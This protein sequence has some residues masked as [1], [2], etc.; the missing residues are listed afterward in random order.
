M[1][2]RDPGGDRAEGW[3]R[4][5]GEA[6]VGWLALGVAVGGGVAYRVIRVAWSG[7]GLAGR[8]AS[9]KGGREIDMIKG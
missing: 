6:A 3:A 4:V 2:L 7:S 9:G 1:R 5:S 8:S